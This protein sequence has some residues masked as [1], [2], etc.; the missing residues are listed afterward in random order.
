MKLI[1]VVFP[2]IL[3]LDCCLSARILV[4]FP[5]GPK[6]HKNSITP[7]A[8]ALAERGHEITLVS[9]FPPTK[10][11]KNIREIVLTE[12]THSLDGDTIKWF[13]MTEQGV[14]QM[15]TMI[16][17]IRTLMRDGYA[18]LMRN[19]EFLA[20]LKER[21]FDLVI[22][23]ALF[24]EFAHAISEYLQVPKIA[25]SAASETPFSFHSMG[26]PNDYAYVPSVLTDFDDRMT[27]F[28]R[29]V[30]MLTAESQALVYKYAAIDLVDEMVKKDFPEARTVAEMEKETSLILMNSHP[31]TAWP[32]SLPPTIIPLGALHTRPAQPLSSVLRQEM[33]LIF[34]VHIR[35]MLDHVSTLHSLLI[36]TRKKPR[37][38]SFYLRSVL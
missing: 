6:S 2:L 16:S 14:T 11:V 33:T 23:D 26:I 18:T 37:T 28:Q 9:S 8:E 29:L 12:L 24:T 10:P 3:L 35:R 21:N 25:R 34:N 32:R 17:Y 5:L 19:P 38:D 15:V 36:N 7:I 1:G 13:E 22:F 4:L 27:F 20:V 31:T 30:N